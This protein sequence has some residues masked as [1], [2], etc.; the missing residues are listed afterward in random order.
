MPISDAFERVD[1]PRFVVFLMKGF[2]SHSEAT[3]V[4]RLRL[5]PSCVEN[6]VAEVRSLVAAKGR[7]VA[8][9]ETCSTSAPEDVNGRLLALG[10]TPYEE[11]V[12][13]DMVVFAPPDPAPGDAKVARV[14]TLE[15]YRRSLEIATERF[16]STTRSGPPALAE[17]Q[18]SFRHLG[19]GR[20]DSILAWI[21]GEAVATGTAD[22]RE[23]RGRHERWFHDPLGEGP[24]CL[25]GDRCGSAG[26]RPFSE[27]PRPSSHRR[28]RCRGRFWSGSASTR[29]RRS[30]SSWT[31]SRRPPFEP[32]RHGS[33]S[34]PVR[35]AVLSRSTCPRA[36]TAARSSRESATARQARLESSAMRRAE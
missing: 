6:A 4:L 21:D 22:V 15:Q 8:T 24:W 26:T 2:E 23:R 27:A 30:G 33:S 35:L 10:M 11:P 29:S 28:A 14:E 5:E 34:G 20:A 7:S 25:R 18:N 9:W 13:A 3:T 32:R 36:G 19:S 16:G 31:P 17:A 1:D 12:A